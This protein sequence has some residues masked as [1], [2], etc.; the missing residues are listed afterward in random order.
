MNIGIGIM[1]ALALLLALFAYLYYYY[2]EKHPI[3]KLVFVLAVL[4]TAF[5]IP[6]AV[7]ELRT[8]CQIVINTTTTSGNTTSNTYMQQCF[9]AQNNSTNT[10]YQVIWSVYQIFILYFIIKVLIMVFT[11]VWERIKRW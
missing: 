3:L 1:F 6:S 2:K 11:P 9:T 4:V 10:F 8:D 7:Y 5:F